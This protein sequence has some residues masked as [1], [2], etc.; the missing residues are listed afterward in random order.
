M[1]LVTFSQGLSPSLPFIQGGSSVIVYVFPCPRLWFD[2]FS[3]VS[4]I[5][6][7]RI[8]FHLVLESL[9]S[10]VFHFIL[11]SLATAIQPRCYINYQIILHV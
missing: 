11:H 9:L 2:C 3:F 4:L 5:L 10:L 6:S 8:P 7:F 1:R